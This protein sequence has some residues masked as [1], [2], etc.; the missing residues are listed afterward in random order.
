MAIPGGKKLA[1]I[2]LR[3]ALD[4]VGI[5]QRRRHVVG[6]IERVVGG[7]RV[8]GMVRVHVGDPEEER[9]VVPRFIPFPAHEVQRP[10]GDPG[11]LVVL[12]GERRRIGRGLRIGS[13]VQF[14]PDVVA[15]LGQVVGVGTGAVILGQHGGVETVPGK[16]VR[17][18]L[19]VERRRRVR[20]L[21]RRS[22]GRELPLGA[23]VHLARAVGAVAVPAQHLHQ[24]QLALGQTHAVGAQPMD[25]RIAPGDHAAPVGCADRIGRKHT[26]EAHALGRQRIDVARVDHLIAVTAQRSRRA[27]DRL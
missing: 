16:F 8:E 13:A 18:R 11:R 23:K 7:R 21:D 3:P 2:G 10:L 24:R 20:I 14:I 4:L 19:R 26:R 1:T 12:F 22:V 15:V 5:P 6:R 27:T 9:L 25:G 17:L